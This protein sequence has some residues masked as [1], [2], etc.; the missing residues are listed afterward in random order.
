MA[1]S[2]D[3][4]RE[5]AWH[6]RFSKA[7]IG[8]DEARARFAN[9]F[10]AEK[11]HHAWLLQG[12]KGV[13]K[14]TF[15]YAL[16][17]DVLAGGNADQA[18]RWIEGRAHPDLFVL[19]REL[20]DAKPRKL[21]AEISVD[22]AR[23]MSQFFSR[24][25]SSG[26][27]VAIVDSADDLSSESANALLKLVEEPPPKALIF[28]VCHQPGR[29]LGTLKSRCLKVALQALSLEETRSVINALPLDADHKNEELA[30]AVSLSGGSPGRALQL[31]GS[32]G[33]KAFS[34]FSK[35]SRYATADLV[36]IGNRF[37]GRGIA[38]EEFSVFCELLQGWIG[39]KA[40]AEDDAALAQAYSTVAEKQRVTTGFNLDKRQAVLEMLCLVR[41]ALKAPAN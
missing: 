31:T 15:A 36:A 17:R 3:D 21:K 6:P 33:A 22:N 19:E 1:D 9:A 24:T 5:V 11:P 38:V 20:N 13:G 29:I 28:L 23:D 16:A 4:L 32:V 26:W 7:V 35:L 27:R 25:S 37:Q 18:R 14:A 40:A 34:E 39:N 12:P 10:A 30:I 41:D 8:H 2:E